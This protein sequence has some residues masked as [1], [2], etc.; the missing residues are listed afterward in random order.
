VTAAPS[1]VLRLLLSAAILGLGTP[2]CAAPPKPP[3]THQVLFV[4]E[5]GN[6]KSLMAASYFNQLAQARGLPFQAVSRGLAPD[7]ATVPDFVKKPMTAAGFDVSGFKPQ[8]L[9]DG[10]IAASDRV[11]AISTS[12][13]SSDAVDASKVEQWSDVPAASVDYAR[14]RDSIKKHVEDL[15]ERLSKH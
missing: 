6:V 4:C 13:R 8:A 5:H 15:I 7:S 2:A 11:V 9:S 1:I 10:D 14:A 12:L 3:A